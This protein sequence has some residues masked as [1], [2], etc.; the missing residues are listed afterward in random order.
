MYLK[1]K[2]KLLRNMHLISIKILSLWNRL[3][4]TNNSS[5]PTENDNYRED[6]SPA[7]EQR[8]NKS[9][10]AVTQ[11]LPWKE[12]ERLQRDTSIMVWI[13]TYPDNHETKAVHVRDTWGKRVD[14][15]LFMSSLD[16]ESVD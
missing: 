12:L 11:S 15:L 10:Y 13:M 4:D 2:I 16:G 9:G 1:N 5:F 14:K 7:N 6:G 8:Q 3:Q